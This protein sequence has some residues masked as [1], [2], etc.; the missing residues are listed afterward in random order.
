[1][2]DELN[3]QSQ[4]SNKILIIVGSVIITAI[5]VGLSV[6]AWQQGTSN[7]ITQ[8]LQQQISSI[9]TD[10]SEI[11]SKLKNVEI[12]I[13]ENLTKQ[14]DDSP[15]KSFQIIT[16]PDI[17]DI[18][19]FST[20]NFSFDYSS[21]MQIHENNLSKSFVLTSSSYQGNG[22]DSPTWDE[23]KDGFKI[24]IMTRDFDPEKREDWKGLTFAAGS[25]PFGNQISIQDIT[26]AGSDDAVIM[27]WES[28]GAGY[29]DYYTEYAETNSLTS[30]H[31]L[32]SDAT[33]YGAIWVIS[34]KSDHD[35][36][37]RHLEIIM[38]SFQ[39]N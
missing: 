18:N 4:D 2:N 24:A 8:Q 21:D 12:L 16:H 10:L 6:Y 31:F 19:T 15:N 3:S 29:E 23:V 28:E 17:A 5:I 25:E 27:L 33:K 13:D 26:V 32:S 14:T 30:Y 20:D 38:N 34:K 11:G 22:N 1:M 36:A 9:N 35:D 39:W 37:N 7:N